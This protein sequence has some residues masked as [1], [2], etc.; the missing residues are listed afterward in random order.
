[1]PRQFLGDVSRE[2]L[3]PI[4]GAGL[5]DGMPSEGL[6]LSSDLRPPTEILEASQHVVE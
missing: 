3:G 6:P 5:A 1:M 4:C 2:T